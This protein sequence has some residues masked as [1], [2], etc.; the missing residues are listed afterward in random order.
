MRR[1]RVLVTTEGTRI[2]GNGE[3]VG[4]LAH[5]HSHSRLPPAARQQYGFRY[6]GRRNWMH[7]LRRRVL[8]VT[9]VIDFVCLCLFI[10]SNELDWTGTQI[11]HTSAADVA[12]ICINALSLVHLLLVMVEAAASVSYRRFKLQYRVKLHYDPER[13]GWGQAFGSYIHDYW[14]LLLVDVGLVLP[15]PLPFNSVDQMVSMT[16]GLVMFVRFFWVVAKIY[17]EYSQFSPH[18]FQITLRLMHIRGKKNHFRY[19]PFKALLFMYPLQFL[20]FSLVVGAGIFGYAIYIAERL[21]DPSTFSFAASLYLSTQIIITGWAGD[22]F[23]KV[24]VNSKLGEAICL[25]NVVF[26]LFVFFWLLALITEW[27]IPTS[28]E[29]ETI[30]TLQ[31]AKLEQ[32]VRIAAAIFIQRWWRLEDSSSP[33]WRK[34]ESARSSFLLAKRELGKFQERFRSDGSS[35]DTTASKDDIDELKA[36]VSRLTIMLNNVTNNNNKA[37]VN[38]N[39]SVN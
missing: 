3:D 6:I 31:D 20:T 32:K 4:L 12:I 8:L 15:Q 21:W 7:F 29:K 35:S 23:S 17:R 5:E 9:G 34:L 24:N 39:N 16:L 22:T 26:G 18:Q 25:L 28:R 14:L 38:N 27:L 10:I 1:R 36:C 19:L 33:L 30:L 2:N 37:L 11:Q 13:V